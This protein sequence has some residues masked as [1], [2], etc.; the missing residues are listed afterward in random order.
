MGE[1]LNKSLVLS[2]WGASSSRLV[3]ETVVPTDTVRL[4]GVNAKSSILTSF[5]AAAFSAVWTGAAGEARC[6]AMDSALPDW[7]AAVLSLPSWPNSMPANPSVAMRTI[8]YQWNFIHL[9][10]VV[11]M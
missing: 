4:A 2:T 8:L 6:A 10:S 1:D 3:H 7:P 9:P 5:A 11:I